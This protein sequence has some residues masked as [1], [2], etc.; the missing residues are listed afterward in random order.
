ML[1]HNGRVAVSLISYTHNALGIREVPKHLRHE[2]LKAFTRNRNF[3]YPDTLT[4]IHL[5]IYHQSTLEK[6]TCENNVNGIRNQLR[7]HCGMFGLLFHMAV[8]M[9]LTRTSNMSSK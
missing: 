6:L 1:R 8:D 7:P 4:Y 3:G 2:N 9:W 5:P